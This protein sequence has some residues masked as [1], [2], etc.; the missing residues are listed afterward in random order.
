MLVRRKLTVKTLGQNCQALKDSESG[1][2]NIDAAK[3][4]GVQ[5]IPFERGVKNKA[6]FAALELSPN[7]RN[8]FKTQSSN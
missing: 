5:K 3:K 1:S 6:Y 2:S 7:K 4:Y 8:T